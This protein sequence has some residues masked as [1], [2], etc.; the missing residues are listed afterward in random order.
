[1]VKKRAIKEVVV[2]VDTQVVMI[3][4]QSNTTTQ[5]YLS[6]SELIVFVFVK[7]CNN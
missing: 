4:D 6:L 1:M 2:I 3:P 7:K 5:K